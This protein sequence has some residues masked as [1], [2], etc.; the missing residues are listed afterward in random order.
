MAG[1]SVSGL[2][3][4]LDTATIINQLMQL[5]AQS[6]TRLKTKVTTEQSAV[7]ALQ[8]LNS[9]LSTLMSKAADLAK[10][11][12]AW[13]TRT[14]STTSPTVTAVTDAGA[15]AASVSFTV[16]K[17]A[18][19]T[20]ATYTTEGTRTAA[21]V[22]ASTPFTM[23]F[24][25]T[26]I[27]GMDTG[28]GSLE[29]IAASINAKAGDKLSAVLVRSGT[30]AGGEATYRLAVSSTSTGAN[31][32]FTLDG[33]LLGPVVA[34]TDVPGADAEITVAGQTIKSSTNTFDELMPGVDVTLGSDTELTKS[35]T[36]TVA[37]D[38]QAL[39]E[40]VK[41]MVDAVNAVVADI[42]T[43][44]NYNSATK[45]AGLL[46][47]DTTLRA[48]RDQIVTAVTSGVAD[49]AGGG[50][51][52]LASVGV[53]VDRSGKLT[54]DADKFKAAY[55]AGP[56]TTMAFFEDADGSGADEGVATRLEALA[57]TFSNSVDGAVTS[58][59][60]GRQSKIDGLNDAIESWDA[61]LA[62]RR[63]ALE[64]QYGALEVALGK[65]Q[66][67]SSWLAGQIASLPSTSS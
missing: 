20:S 54:F 16:D 5:E 41:A 3:S 10:S 47:G 33:A 12:G 64:R 8:S 21:V 18:T 65:L 26:T 53:Q 4:G 50:S 42:D 11:T 9:K 58:L 44:T 49:P 60:K 1:T 25:G 52:S 48:V 55:A 32:D 61:R 22:A 39:T 28:D 6:Q 19:R 57:K 23:T 30:D 51:L 2:V 34:G 36:V 27:S 67:Q 31:T 59:V 37:T 46:A 40:K 43:L 56:A 29:D 17:L 38:P 24:H 13:S 62:L 7:T 66:S 45:K 63:T 14:A 35:V 15:T